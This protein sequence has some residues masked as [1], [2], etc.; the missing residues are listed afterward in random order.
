VKTSRLS[1]QKAG[2]MQRIMR[3]RQKGARLH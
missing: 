3:V 2:L 1:H